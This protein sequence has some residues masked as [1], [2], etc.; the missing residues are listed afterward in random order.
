MQWFPNPAADL[1]RFYDS[2]QIPYI[3]I[4]PHNPACTRVQREQAPVIVSLQ[5]GKEYLI[6]QDGGE[7]LPL[8]AQPANDVRQLYWYVN[9]RFVG[10][11]E[12]SGTVFLKPLAGTSKISCSDDKGRNRDIR[13]SVRF[14]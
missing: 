5:D 7:Q 8:N 10:T 2:E 9:D 1:A 4:P 11:C 3:K 6:E 14:Y 13:I 12:P